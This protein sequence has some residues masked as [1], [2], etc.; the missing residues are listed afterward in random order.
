MTANKRHILS[1]ISFLYKEKQYL[2][3]S[4][5]GDLFEVFD[6]SQLKQ[7]Q[8]LSND[9]SCWLTYLFCERLLFYL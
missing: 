7:N 4:G 5:D 3:A 1:V 6:V 2:G 8:F 9:N